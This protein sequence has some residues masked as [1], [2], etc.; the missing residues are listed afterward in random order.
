MG[1]GLGA[2]FFLGAAFLGAGAAFLA[3]AGAA[4]LKR[5]LTWRTAILYEVDTEVELVCGVRNMSPG[6]ARD[7]A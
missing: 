5:A 4:F 1:A 7:R 2:A 6:G 3:G